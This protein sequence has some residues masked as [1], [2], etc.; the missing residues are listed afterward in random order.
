MPSDFYNKVVETYE[1][2]PTTEERIRENILLAAKDSQ[3]YYRSWCLSSQEASRLKKLFIEEGF[4]VSKCIDM[5]NPNEEYYL[6][7]WWAK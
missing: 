1:N 5:G 3:N 2:R 4:K 6:Q 7:I